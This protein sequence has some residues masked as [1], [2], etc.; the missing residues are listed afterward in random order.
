MKKNDQNVPN[1]ENNIIKRE[2]INKQNISQKLEHNLL[3]I[4]EDY[5]NFVEDFRQEELME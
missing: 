1:S 2:I 3:T 4:T 5:S